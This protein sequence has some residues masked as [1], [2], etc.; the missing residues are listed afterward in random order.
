MDKCGFTFGRGQKHEHIIDNNNTVSE[1]CLSFWLENETGFLRVKLYDKLR[2]SLETGSVRAG[3]G[4]HL[5][6][7][8][9]N[10]GKHLRT[11]F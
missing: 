7:W 8:I 9:N 6:N 4:S 10:P 3:V 5:N 1:T 2:Q 11:K